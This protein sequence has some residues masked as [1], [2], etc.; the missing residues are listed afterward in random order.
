MPYI[1]VGDPDIPTTQKMLEAVYDAG[2]QICELGFPFSDPIADGPV[3]QASMKR[4]LDAGANVQKILHMVKQFRKSSAPSAQKLGLIAMLSFSM[5]YKIGTKQFIEQ[6]KDAGIDGLIIPDLPIEQSQQVTTIISDAG[7]ICSFLVSPSTPIARAKKI[8]A[9][10]T[11][12]LYMVARAGVTGEQKQIP[13]DLTSRITD[14]RTVTDLPIAVGFGIST[15]R[16][17]TQVVAVADAAIVGSAY[18]KTVERAIQA[19]KNN[20]TQDIA[21]L[22]S[23]L[24][25]GLQ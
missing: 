11:G 20:I 5:I 16:H 14:L 7:L 10:S 1:T 23:Q 12:F 6:C 21:Q 22:T 19:Q 4:A 17:V 13:Q 2:A 25:A 8:A 24:V 9:I 18:M 15:P 3:I